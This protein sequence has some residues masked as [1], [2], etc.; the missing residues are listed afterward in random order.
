MFDAQV[1]GHGGS[2]ALKALGVSAVVVRGQ[3]RSAEQV[4]L[5]LADKFAAM[6]DGATKAALALRL[7]GKEGVGIIPFLN[8]GRE[9]LT[10]L[11][12]EVLYLGLVKSEDVARAA[13]SAELGFV[14]SCHLRKDTNMN[15]ICMHLSRRAGPALADHRLR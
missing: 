6:P 13:A 5:D 15:G 2:E 10:A 3:I 7:F 8:Q 4:L 1:H 9:G 12:E 14:L 11:K